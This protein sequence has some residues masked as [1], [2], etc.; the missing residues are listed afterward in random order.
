MTNGV[1][2]YELHFSSSDLRS[3]QVL[4]HPL[5]SASG[6]ELQA[7]GHQALGQLGLAR[8]ASA[9]RHAPGARCQAVRRRGAWNL[10]PGAKKLSG[11]Q[12][13]FQ[14]LDVGTNQRAST[15][16]WDVLGVGFL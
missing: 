3:G 5:L 11:V 13:E 6:Q 16:F 7:V 8:L 12:P 1:L 4:L 10:G 2:S 9:T 14:P 15:P